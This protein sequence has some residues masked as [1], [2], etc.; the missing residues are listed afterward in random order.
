MYGEFGWAM[1]RTLARWSRVTKT[2]RDQTGLICHRSK[3]SQKSST[4]SVCWSHA[5]QVRNANCVNLFVLI[6]FWFSTLLQSSSSDI[7][8]TRLFGVS[9]S[10]CSK[11]K[12]SENLGTLTP[13]FQSEIYFTTRRKTS[14]NWRARSILVLA[15]KFLPLL[16]PVNTS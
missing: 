1:V 16:R 13:L 12:F 14:H 5:C 6:L 11:S 9:F 15:G 4:E 2:M 7:F 10:K 3:L 8:L